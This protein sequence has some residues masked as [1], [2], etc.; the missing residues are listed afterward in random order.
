MEDLA[1]I[2]NRL[3][4]DQRGFLAAIWLHY[5]AEGQWMPVRALHKDAGGKSVVRPVL[6][7]IG[8]SAVFEMESNGIL[9]Y[10]LTYLGILLSSRG[11][12][13]EELLCRYLRVARSLALQ[14]PMRTA[15]SSEEARSLLGLEPIEVRMLG[16]AL[17]IS[18][19][20][21]GGQ[22]G[23]DQWNAL[24]PR[25]IEDL[26][27][28]PTVRVREAAAAN[29]DPRVPLQSFERTNYYLAARSTPSEDA[30][31]FVTDHSLRATASQDWTSAKSCFAQKAWKP[32]VIAGGSVLEAILLDALLPDPSRAREA[33]GARRPARKPPN[34]LYR[35][36]LVDLVDASA[37]LGLIS[38]ASSH[39]GHALRLHRDL[40]HPGRQLKHQ[41]EV[42]EVEAQMSVTIVEMCIRDLSLRPRP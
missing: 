10:Q 34:D 6:Q 21:A 26:P 29:F 38:E 11:N 2:R 39:L 24:L 19:F 22:S 7:Q 20:S 32:C 16:R 25:D 1:T 3:T 15:V 42:S 23:A 30:F 37:E 36:N 17:F 27:D 12:L 4:D 33:L 31:A 40:V 9:Y 41:L 35:W 14:E 13:V 5:V 28:D 18:P 8:G